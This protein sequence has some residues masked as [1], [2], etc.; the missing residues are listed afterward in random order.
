MSLRETPLSAA[1]SAL[2]SRIASFSPNKLK[3]G[4]FGSNCSSGRAATRVPERWSASWEDNLKLAQMADAAGI[5]LMI[6]VGRWRGYGGETNFEGSSWESVTWACGL[7]A[8]TQRVN[9]FATVHAPLVHPVYAAKQF[10]TVDHVSRGRF[11]LNVVCGWNQDEFDMFGVEQRA[12]DDRYEYGEEWLGAIT[13]MW[14]RQGDFDFDGKHIKLKAVQA[15]P[16]PYG[17]TRPLIMN[18]GSSPAGRAFSTRACDVLFRPLRTLQSGAED[19]RETIAAA[20]AYG[21][22]IGVFC[23]GYVV[24]RK[25]RKEAEEYHRYYAE[26]MGDWAAVDHLIA[27]NQINSQSYP[28]EFLKAFRIRFAAGHGGFPMVGDPDDVAAALA[29]VSEAGFA[30]ICFSFVNYVDEFPFFR[31]EVLPRLTRM[32]LREEPRG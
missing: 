21:R 26:E 8:Q 18:A 7:L 24:C 17:G 32:E 13:Q 29:S 14:Q 3:L 20:A 4:L 2:P 23:N 5:D 10:V 12:H 28:P 16:K 31:D 19:V 25:T 27:M 15:E 22:A 6:P 30:G 11:G 9:I 1:A